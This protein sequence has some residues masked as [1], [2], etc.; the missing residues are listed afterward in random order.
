MR[1][2]TRCEREGGETVPRAGGVADGGS[3][4]DRGG[5]L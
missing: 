2:R 1:S 4:N 3:R 5:R